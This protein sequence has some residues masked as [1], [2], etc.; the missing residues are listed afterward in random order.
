ML[1]Q[2]RN[3]FCFQLIILMALA[4]G[5][6]SIR[7]GPVTLH[8]ETAIH[9]AQQLT[10]VSRKSLNFKL[11][12]AERIFET[13]ALQPNIHCLRGMYTFYRFFPIFLTTEK[14]STIKGNNLLLGRGLTLSLYCVPCKLQGRKKMSFASPASMAIL[15]ILTKVFFIM[16]NIQAIIISSVER[17]G[18]HR[19][20][21]LL[22]KALIRLGRCV[23]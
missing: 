20:Q 17:P 6:S 9:V 22:V 11:N 5:K 13:L 8:T 1:C 4:K 2:I 15:L 7:C 10:H 12:G 14:D 16:L 19:S 3:F 18:G 23:F 21:M